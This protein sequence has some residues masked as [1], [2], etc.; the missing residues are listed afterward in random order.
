[1]GYDY[2]DDLEDESDNDAGVLPMI[3]EPMD[4]EEE[5]SD[6]SEGTFDTFDTDDHERFNPYQRERFE[7]R[8]KG[9]TKPF[10]R[11]FAI[12]RTNKQVYSEAM[13]MFYSEA[14]LV[15]DPG[16]IFSLATHTL[17]F[18]YAHEVA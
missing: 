4:E 8:L 17:E 18:G 14:V 11:S 5:N 6:D 16:D 1:M 12:L 9:E 7:W 2:E 10:R 15:L 13:S 3:G